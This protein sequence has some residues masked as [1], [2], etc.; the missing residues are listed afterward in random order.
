MNE[1]RVPPDEAGRR[2]DV[3]LSAR[4]PALS[5]ARVQALIRAGHARV[6]GRPAKPSRTVAAGET[7]TLEVPPPQPTA[8]RAEA[9][10]LVVAYEDAD[11]IVVDKAPGMVVHPAAGHAAGTLV[12][13]LLAHIPD[14]AGI[15]GE[16]RPGIVHRLDRDTSGLL[17]AAKNEA[18][19]RGLVA[20]FRGRQVRKEYLALVWG[21]PQPPAGRAETLIGRSRHDR[22]KMSTRPAGGGRPAVTH[23]ETAECFCDTALLRVRIETGRT[24]Q[25]RV[26]LA[27][28]GHP[29]VGDVQYGRARRDRLPAPAARQMLHAWRLGFRHPCTGQALALEAPVPDDMAA[30]LGALRKCGV[31][32]AERGV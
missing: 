32:S 5:R 17:V 4:Q 18:A 15:G 24:H 22:K 6:N 28:L 25:I 2:L 31:R 20:Q 21:H 9:L 16:L 29:V 13:A 7:V 27:H 14:L 8:L 1:W 30:L 11:I 10:P 3:W 12:N 23:Y 19:L 26:H